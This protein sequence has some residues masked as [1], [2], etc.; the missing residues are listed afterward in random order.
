MS[1]YIYISYLLTLLLNVGAQ[2]PDGDV[3]FELQSE[4][5][6]FIL[7]YPECSELNGNVLILNEVYNLSSFINIESIDGS[8]Y[9]DN[10]DSLGSLSGL[11]NLES[12][13][14]SLIISW[15]RQGFETLAGLD[16]LSNIGKHLYIE[17]TSN[18]KA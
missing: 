3:V 18:L 16:K 14:E 9:I 5:D 8:L 6:H 15:N 12:I 4:I 2:C 1:K 7:D 10:N 17:T 13:G 11:N